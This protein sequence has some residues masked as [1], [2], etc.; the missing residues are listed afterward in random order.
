M[1]RLLSTTL[2]VAM[3]AA[4]PSSA[5]QAD[6]RTQMIRAVAHELGNYVQ[7]VDPETLSIQQLA[8][9]RSIM[10]SSR[11]ESDKRGL[12][13]SAVGG[14]NSLRSLLFGQQ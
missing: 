9:I 5:A 8:A 7:G 11:S 13:R 6:G 4:M 3:L 14:R 1:T 10:Y 12:I 2:V